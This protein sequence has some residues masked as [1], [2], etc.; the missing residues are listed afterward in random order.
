MSKEIF[1]VLGREI[2]KLRK[3][4]GITAKELALRVNLSRTT[5]SK[6][7][8]GMQGLSLVSYYRIVKE[9]KCENMND[10]FP[11]DTEYIDPDITKFMND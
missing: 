1:Q 11:L 7:E 3:K 6:F 9:L 4:R 10:I 2:R 8:N 5:I